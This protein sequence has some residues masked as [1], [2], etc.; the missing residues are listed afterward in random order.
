M[1]VYRT[2]YGCA[3]DPKTCQARKAVSDQIKGL[4]VTSIKWRCPDRKD[5]FHVGQAVWATTHSG[6]IQSEY[7]GGGYIGDFPAIIIRHQGARAVVMIEPGAL[8]RT[9]RAPFTPLN[10]GNGF[11][12][13][14]LTR[15]KERDAPTVAVCP[16]CEMPDGLPHQSG[17][18]CSFV[19]EQ[20][21]HD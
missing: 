1:T 5:R 4:G 15:L 11:C 6:V 7:D 12:K 2:C 20:S 17:W 3:A 16:T 19:L 18:S 21:S 9:E 10:A 13:I 14:P 8:D